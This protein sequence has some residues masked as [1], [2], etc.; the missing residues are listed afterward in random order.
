MLNLIDSTVPSLAP[1]FLELVG[2]VL[3][4]VA[5]VHT[6]LV[7]KFEEIAAGYPVGSI[8][9]NVFH[10]LGEVE[11]VF[12]I[13]GGVFLVIYTISNGFAV[14]D[15]HHNVVGGMVH[16]LNGL[17]YTEPVFVFVIMCMSATR[18]II[19]MTERLIITISRLLPVSKSISFYVTTL[20]VGP[21][22]GSF[23]TEPAAMTVTALIL[24][25]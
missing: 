10:F 18:P 24:L 11:A 1:S 25:D 19:L 21:L 4:F 16:Y 8:R 6:F 15:D 20:I 12:G 14:F 2:T 3:F 13:W 17:N 7:K 9:E 5:V 23:I 22:L